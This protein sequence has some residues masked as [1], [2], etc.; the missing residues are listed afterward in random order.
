[1]EPGIAVIWQIE[2]ND[3]ESEIVFAETEPPKERK[4]CGREC[5]WIDELAENKE[6]AIV[7][8]AVLTQTQPALV[9]NMKRLGFENYICLDMELMTALE[10][11]G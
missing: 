11:M 10:C 1:M 7:I 3:V 2:K 4:V 6:K 9:A 8:I 5:L